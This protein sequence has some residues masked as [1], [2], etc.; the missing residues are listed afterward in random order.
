MSC[1]AKVSSAIP[2]DDVSC[3]ALSLYHSEKPVSRRA[4]EVTKAG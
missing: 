2:F 1:S 3:L 4:F